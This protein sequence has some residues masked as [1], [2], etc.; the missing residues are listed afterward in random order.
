MIG[1]MGR[2]PTG[3][4]KRAQSNGLV[5]DLLRLLVGAGL[6]TAVALVTVSGVNSAGSKVEQGRLNDRV[7]L[8]NA[9]AHPL[10][11]WLAGARAQ[12]SAVASGASPG[13]WDALRVDATGAFVGL[14]GRY[15][16]LSG[17]VQSHPCGAGAGLQE[18][19]NAVKQ[20]SGPAALVVESVGFCDPVIGAAA[21]A[22]GGVVVVTSGAD[23]F[24]AQVAVASHFE[25]GIRTLVIDPG[26]TVVSPDAAVSTVPSY[27]LPFAA[28]AAAGPALGD[29]ERTGDPQRPSVVDAG[30][31]VDGG[32]AVVV[33]QD[34]RNFDVGEVVK[35]SKNVVLIVGALF[36]VILLLQ[37]ISDFRRRAVARHKDAHTAA[38]LAVLSHE[39]RTP[40]TVIKG[41]I[42]TLA[43]RW[44]ALT[45]DQRHDLV[46]R[47][48][49]Q[50]RRLNRVVDRLN[51]AA[52]LQAGASPKL[53]LAP[54]EVERALA[55][56]ADSYTAA[57]PLHEFVVDAPH[58]VVARADEKVLDQILDQL[59]DNAVKYSPEGG[60]VRLSACRARGR[61]EITVDDEGVGLPRDL[62]A[63]FDAFTQ[64]E[65]VD[66]RVHDEGG[67]GVGL[68]IVRQLC[69]QLDGSVRA[70]RRARGARL[71]VTLR[72]SRVRA[73]TRV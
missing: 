9:L 21:P 24:L 48:A 25:S 6:L 45:D 43:G 22:A 28:R 35:P 10:G 65:D 5:G 13:Q 68:Y 34:S 67:V 19:V 41:F 39:L 18:L 31:P 58:D 61:V 51:L 7:G 32:W 8:A 56:A 54:V 66:G 46:D 60:V 57:A 73:L 23:A 59:V 40:L 3:A 49:P 44:D 72:A 38:F 20:R 2:S 1:L 17:T 29:R 70:E 33:E 50:S 64:G 16:H 27:L 11:D 55:R 30:A 71:V 15:Q 36:G 63:I 4:R 47:L 62:G 26:G 42:D 37:A 53:T 52:K 12:A 69:E 14:S